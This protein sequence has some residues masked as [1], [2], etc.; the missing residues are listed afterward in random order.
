MKDIKQALKMFIIQKVRDN[1]SSE[2]PYFVIKWSGLYELTKAYNIELLSLIDEMEKEGLIRKVL[3]PSKKNKQ[4]KFLAI[5]LPE[6]VSSKKTRLM[7]NEFEAF[8]KSLK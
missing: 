1:T 8:Q 6:N 3:L 4:H 7:I 2:K 5:C